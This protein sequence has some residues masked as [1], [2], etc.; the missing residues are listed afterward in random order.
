MVRK[1]R[2]MTGTKHWNAKLTPADV[3]NI[4]MLYGVGMNSH[5]IGDEYG[6]SPSQARLIGSGKSWRASAK[7]YE[8]A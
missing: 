2:S 7:T 3:E 1:G 8:A 6:I 4:R 5:Y